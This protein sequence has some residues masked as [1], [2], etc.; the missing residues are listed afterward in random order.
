M[1]LLSI[2]WRH[3][4]A[5]K[6]V[7]GK[8]IKNS[9]A[10][11]RMITIGN[12]KQSI[13]IR[14]ENKC[15]PVLLLLHG[16]PGLTETG[17]FRYYNY[18][19]EKNFVVVY[20]D[21]RA[22]GKSYTK[23]SAKEP[24][25]INMYVEDTCELSQYLILHFK[26]EKI[27]LLG[28]SWGTM[29]GIMAAY[30]KPELFYAY[31]GTGQVASM[32]DGE[33]ES[34]KFALKSAIKNKNK[35]AINE[36]TKIEQPENGIYKCGNAGTKIER[37]WLTYFGG[38]LYGAKSFGKFLNKIITPREYNCI[39]IFHVFKSMN[40]P[41]RNKMSTT[42]FLKSNLFKIVKKL[43]VPVYFFLGRHDYQ[44]PSI[45]AEKYFNYLKAPQKTLVWF[46]K[47][48]HCPCFEESNK[49]NQLMTQKVLNICKSG[50]K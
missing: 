47:S 39:D 24:L 29:I 22:C 30:R 10:E 34:Y 13:L 14:G 1:T 17:L 49:F 32:P 37:K 7:N 8:I 2:F 11:M 48:V 18:D 16:G 4:P 9:I 46:E 27:F 44:I 33:L 12:T 38:S 26:K 45:V 28:H 5:F 43:D 3:T 41:P 31:V 15:N 19:L 6:D 35:K 36:L 40:L 23:R 42:E 50:S 25:S 21:Q 20:W